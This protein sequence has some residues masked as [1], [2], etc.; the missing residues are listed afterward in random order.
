MNPY[1]LYVSR[2]TTQRTVS[3][4]FLHGQRAETQRAPQLTSCK[5]KVIKRRK[6]SIPGRH[7]K[8]VDEKQNRCLPRLN[9]QSSP[10]LKRETGFRRIW[11][12]ASALSITIYDT[13]SSGFNYTLTKLKG[14]NEQDR[15]GMK[16]EKKKRTVP[17]KEAI[18]GTVVRWC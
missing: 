8:S 1:A 16:E 17:V 6:K 5:V 15:D 10:L 12:T 13:L 3:L 9:P 4:L 11:F 7:H 14:F 2:D 18:T